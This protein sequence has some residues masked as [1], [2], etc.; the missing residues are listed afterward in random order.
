MTCFGVLGSAHLQITG[1]IGSSAVARVRRGEFSASFGG[2]GLTIAVAL[3]SLGDRVEFATAV[4]DRQINLMILD[5]LRAAGIG[6]HA[7]FDPL[8]PDAGESCHYMPNGEVW[9]GVTATP[10]ERVQFRAKQIDKVI[11]PAEE[12]IVEATLHPHTIEAAILRATAQNKRVWIAAAS[13]YAVPH[14]LPVLA[15]GVRPAGLFVKDGE[16]GVA[17]REAARTRG[18][19]A[20]PPSP[21]GLDTALN[22]LLVH[23]T[24]QLQTCTLWAPDRAVPLAETNS[25]HRAVGSPNSWPDLADHFMATSLH[26]MAAEQL[27]MSEAVARGAWRVRHELLERSHAKHGDALEARLATLTHDALTG[28]GNRHNLA[29]W[30]RRFDDDNEMALLMIDLDHFKKINDTFGH[31]TGDI[32]LAQVGTILRA[33]VRHQDRAF[34]VG[35]EEM[36]VLLPDTPIDAA[37]DVAE[38]IRGTIEAHPFA[39]G[40]VTSSIGVAMGMVRDIDP[41]REAADHALYVAKEGGRNRVVLASAL[42]PTPEKVP[43]SAPSAPSRQL[44]LPLLAV[45]G[46]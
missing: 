2:T 3:A 14:L 13:E 27:P 30:L 15:K 32:V 22:G 11:D 45:D 17:I 4:P 12:V 43:D 33:A 36:M 41:M 31:D 1:R 26:L 37:R 24:R 19:G 9:S 20:M 6:V 44:A 5:A 7:A 34:R 29:N 10:I 35:G 16:L 38:R 42:P 40:R 28:L 39:H 23:T 18:L 8:L 46:K 25:E 21:P